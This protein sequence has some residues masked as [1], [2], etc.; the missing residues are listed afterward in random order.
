MRSE[1]SE[2]KTF[3]EFAK[4]PVKEKFCYFF[5]EFGS[6]SIIYYLVLTY[7]VFF[8]QMSCI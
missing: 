7:S 3:S 1:S 2:L 6:Q 5:G 8:T 4:V